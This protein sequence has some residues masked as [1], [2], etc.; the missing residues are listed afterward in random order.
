MDS[1]AVPPQFAQRTVRG[2]ARCE[3][4][5]V[6]TG[7]WVSMTIRAGRPDTGIQ[8]VRSDLPPGLGIIPARIELLAGVDRRLVLANVHGHTV[9]SVEHLL[10]ALVACGVDNATVELDGPE[11][12]TLDG[13]AREFVQMILRAGR[14]HQRRVRRFVVIE[15]MIAVRRGDRRAALL[16]SDVPRATLSIEYA[17]RG[18][19]FQ[20]I[21]TALDEETL[22]RDIGDA[23]CFGF[24]DE[25]G[26]LRERGLALG[27]SLLNTVV[28]D[29]GRAANPEGLR[30]PDELIR[31]K[32]LDCVGGLA[33]AGAPIIGHVAAH[34]PGHALM[35]DLV[36]AL[37]THPAAWSFVRAG[38][39]PLGG[40][41]R[42]RP[43]G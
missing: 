34:K 19:D 11:V 21:S 22:Q 20:C 31:H 9:Q 3:G 18:I 23:R 2:T 42:L 5:G 16:P 39:A 36:K 13:S 35:T 32:V 41:N 1:V 17:E 33:L 26:E 10:A 28:L 7:R 43:P 27:A 38:A 37:Q 4:I 24:L 29:E 30:S 14:A 25:A 40:R 15:R 12:P 6:H 8:F